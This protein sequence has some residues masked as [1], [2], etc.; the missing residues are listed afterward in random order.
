MLGMIA[1][2]DLHRTRQL[3]QT[4]RSTGLIAKIL[5]TLQQF[6]QA[7]RILSAFLQAR[8]FPLQHNTLTRRNRKIPGRTITFTIAALNALINEMKELQM[9]HFSVMNKGFISQND[10]PSSLIEKTDKCLNDIMM[11]DLSKI[12]D[13]KREIFL[14]G[15][16]NLLFF[17]RVATKDNRFS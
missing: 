4:V 14:D 10:L 5:I 3:T 15:M 13:D 17:S 7:F 9:E 8:D 16:F 1:G 11:Y 2:I 12:S 6:R